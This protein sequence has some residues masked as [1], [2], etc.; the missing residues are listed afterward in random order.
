MALLGN[1]D[2]NK[3]FKLDIFKIYF[4]ENITTCSR[5]L[6][7]NKKRGQQNLSHGDEFLRTIVN[8]T[9]DRIGN[10]NI[11]FATRGR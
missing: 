8:K 1:K 7:K 3:K 5:Y 2:I 9:K 11:R 6:D 10:T 4:Q